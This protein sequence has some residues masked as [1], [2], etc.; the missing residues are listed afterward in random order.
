M[1]KISPLLLCLLSALRVQSQTV[2]YITFMDNRI[3]NHGYLDFDGVGKVLNNS[4]QC[5]TDLS[6]CCSSAEGPHRGDW[7]FPSGSR[8]PFYSDAAHERR[9][10]QL[11]VLFNSGIKYISGIYSC[12]I[13]VN[14]ENSKKIVHVGLYHNGG[15]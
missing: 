6:T 5:H 14:G 12:T 4:V 11:V 9:T 13:A 8:L 1:S 7:Y 3:P 2:P 15:E 10:A